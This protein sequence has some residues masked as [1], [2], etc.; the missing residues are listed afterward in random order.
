MR[1]IYCDLKT[2]PP[3]I[4]ILYVT[5]EKISSSPQFQDTLDDLY[6]KNYISRFVIDEAHCVSQWGHDF[7]PDYKRLGILRKRFPKVPTMALTATATP[8]VRIDILRQLNLTHTK[9]FLSSFNRN[10]LKYSVLPKRGVSTLDDIKAFIRARP[11]NWCGIVY[12]LS[13]KECEDVANKLH[14]SGIQSLAY[15][16]GLTDSMRE[17]RQKDWLTGKVRVIC[18]TIAFGMGIDKPDVRFVLHF[19]LPKSIEGY[20]QEAGRAGRDGDI[21]HC[22][23]Y[24][25]YSDMM[26]MKKLLDCM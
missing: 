12:C 18:A 24:Y 23:L 26:R 11:S 21:A 8:R 19:S 1:A 3:R 22:V 9:W 5:P 10:N 4:K 2:S 6:A 13:R 15:H 7:R 14:A 17:T 16:A 20:Y 25:N